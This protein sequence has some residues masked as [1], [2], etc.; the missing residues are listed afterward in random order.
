MQITGDSIYNLTRI[1]EVET[2]EDDRPL[3][4]LPTITS[5]E[6]CSLSCTCS[7]FLFLYCTIYCSSSIMNLQLFKSVSHGIFIA[8]SSLSVWSLVR[9]I[10]FDKAPLIECYFL[11]IPPYLQ[12]LLWD[13]GGVPLFFKC[14]KTY[15][16]CVIFFFWFK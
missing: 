8:L 14:W 11:L 4:P 3:D 1:G 13:E 15:V 12:W 10:R 6:V 2:G 16:L 9:G 7:C 5:V